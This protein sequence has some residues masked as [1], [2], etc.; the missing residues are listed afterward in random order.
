MRKEDKLAPE[1]ISAQALHQI[2]VA[3]GG[4]IP[5][6]HPSSTFVRDENYELLVPEHSYGREIG[7][8]TCGKEC[9]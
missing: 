8:A 3:T 5:A 9:P 4:V 7:R 6:I 2:D 1:T